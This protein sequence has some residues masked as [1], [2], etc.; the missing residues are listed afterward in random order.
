MAQSFAGRSFCPNHSTNFLTGITSIP[1]IE[2]IPKRREII[3]ALFTV[4]IVIDCNK[5]YV[6]FWEH[7]FSI[8]TNLQIV[9]SETGHILYNHHVDKTSFNI[10]QHLL[11]S[12]SVK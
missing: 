7:H 3:I 11:K 1:L 5:V 8:H 12:R 10:G 6:L 2:Q 4:N 9:T